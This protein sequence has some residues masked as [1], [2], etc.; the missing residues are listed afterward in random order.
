[1]NKMKRTRGFF[2]LLLGVSL[3]GTGVARAQELTMRNSPRSMQ[4]IRPLGMGGAFLAT[5]G[6][7][8]NALFYNPAAISDYEKKFHFQ[9]LLPT[10]EFSYKAIPFFSSDLLDLA[11]DIDNAATDG[12]KV[13]VFDAFAAANTGRYEEIGVRGPVAIM[14]HKYITAAIFYEN[15]SAMGLLNPASSTIDIESTSQ[16][17][18]QVGSAWSFFDKKIKVGGALKFLGRH[19][20]NEKITQRD[21]VVNNDFS[22]AIA[23]DQFGFGLGFDLGFQAKI[24]FEA[25]WWKYLDPTFGL[26]IQDIGDTRFFM[27]DD[28]GRIEESTSL[29]FAIHPD[30]WKLKTQ[31]ALDIRD[32]EHSTDGITKLHFGYEVTWPEIGKVLRSASVR[33]GL[34][35]GYLAGG[36]GLDFKYFKLNAA[37]YGREIGLRTRQKESRMFGLQL[38]SG[39]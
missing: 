35:Q 9:F 36:F 14:M 1:M 33:V 15:R 26:T 2:L 6:T 3:L 27:G 37:T 30:Y 34:N 25:N 38:A 19:L 18:V 12:D 39:F 7:D 29:G 5:D 32:L 16:G 13:N 4:G 24:P 20:I 21:I 22:D 10:V 17:G 23:T 28:V 8:E 31:F 11:D